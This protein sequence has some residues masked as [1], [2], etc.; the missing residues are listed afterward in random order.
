M[1]G[2]RRQP[3]IKNGYGRSAGMSGVPQMVDDLRCNAKVVGVGLGADY[4]GLQRIPVTFVVAVAGGLVPATPI[5]LWYE[6]PI[7]HI[8][9]RPQSSTF[10][11]F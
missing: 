1:V 9:P 6:P 10:T 8:R 7:K 11:N 2:R 4:P 3:W 5:I